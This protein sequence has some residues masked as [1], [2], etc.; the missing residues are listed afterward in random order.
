[1]GNGSRGKP[2]PVGGTGTSGRYAR[3]TSASIMSGAFVWLAI[4]I[5]R[6]EGAEGAMGRFFDVSYVSTR[7]CKEAGRW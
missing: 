2:D 5:R 6:D 4:I 1:M 3:G 7:S